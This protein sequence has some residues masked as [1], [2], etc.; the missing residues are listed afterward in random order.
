MNRKILGLL[1]G[2]AYGDALGMPSEMMSRKTM[3]RAFPKGIDRFLPSSPYDF[4]GRHFD[5]GRITDDTVNTLL[6]CDSIIDHNG[7]FETESYIRL[8]RSWMENNKEKVGYMMGPSTLKAI[9]AI[10]K[11]MP[12]E[13]AGIFGTTNGAAMKVSP[14]GIICDYQKIDQLIEVVKRLCMPT[15]NTN[16]AITGASIIASLSSY[17]LRTSPSMEKMWKLAY[18]V[19]E[20]CQGKGNELPSASLAYRLKGVEKLLKIRT[21]EEVL[22]ELEH[23]YG[24]GMETIETIPTVMAL[25]ELSAFNPYQ[26]ARMAANL[27]GDTDTIGSIATAICGAANPIFSAEDIHFLSE[28]NHID[29]TTYARQLSQYL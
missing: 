24:T 23:F 3:D 17:A 2:C 10:E 5:A 9:A 12:I 26:C 20:C 13:K 21:Q 14:L 1:V 16:I 19:I 7:Q 25:I 15:H 18:R 4:I 22:Y 27:S 28:V 6:V 29:F 11:G 8:L